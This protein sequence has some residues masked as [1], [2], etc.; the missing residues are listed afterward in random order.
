[1]KVTPQNFM[2]MSFRCF[3]LEHLQTDY[4]YVLRVVHCPTLMGSGE[5]P[6]S[7]REGSESDKPC[8]A[9]QRPHPVRLVDVRAPHPHLFTVSGLTLSPCQKA[10]QWCQDLNSVSADWLNSGSRYTRH[11]LPAPCRFPLGCSSSLTVCKMTVGR[12]LMSVPQ[13]MCD[14]REGG[15]LQE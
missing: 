13:R 3:R 14:W 5:I 10:E 9:N 2:R 8:A 4:S 1:M 12:G 15:G 6:F 7:K 11:V